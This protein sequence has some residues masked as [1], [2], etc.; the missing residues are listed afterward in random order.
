MSEI[1]PL[2][3][4]T[5]DFGKAQLLNQD[6]HPWSC[7]SFSEAAWVHRYYLQVIGFVREL[8]EKWTSASVSEFVLWETEAV[9][10]ARGIHQP[11]LQVGRCGP[12]GAVLVPTNPAGGPGLSAFHGAAA[13]PKETQHL[14]RVLV[15]FH[16]F[17]AGSQ[18]QGEKPPRLSSEIG[19]CAPGEG[20]QM[21]RSDQPHRP[22]EGNR[23]ATE[24]PRSARPPGADGPLGNA[25]LAPSRGRC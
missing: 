10:T 11:V 5:L 1:P 25:A 4:N 20:D 21:S 19:P 16:L 24:T 13:P 6:P 23:N 7:R 12:R 8:D 22:W 18:P 15:C 9:R 14:G 2:F 3:S 17:S